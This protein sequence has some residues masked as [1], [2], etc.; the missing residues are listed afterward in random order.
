MIIILKVILRSSSSTILSAFLSPY[1][2]L[3]SDQPIGELKEN[4]ELANIF[5]KSPNFFSS[6]AHRLTSMKMNFNK[7]FLYQFKASLY[8]CKYRF[9]QINDEI[10][11]ELVSRIII[12]GNI[13]FIH[14]LSSLTYYSDILLN[15][16]THLENIFHLLTEI[17]RT[18]S[19]YCS[20][21]LKGVQVKYAKIVQSNSYDEEDDVE[22]A[23]SIF[24]ENYEEPG[25][26]LVGIGNRT[27]FQPKHFSCPML[28]SLYIL[29]SRIIY[30]FPHYSY[31]FLSYDYPFSSL[32]SNSSS[33]S[34]FSFTF[35]DQ[36]L[37]DISSCLTSKPKIILNYINSKSQNYLTNGEQFLAQSLNFTNTFYQQFMEELEDNES[38]SLYSST[39]DQ[40][41]HRLYNSLNQFFLCLNWSFISIQ[42]I[43]IIQLSHSITPSDRKEK[44]KLILQLANVFLTRG[45]L[46]LNFTSSYRAIERKNRLFLSPFD[47]TSQESNES[48]GETKYLLE[49]KI[50]LLSA[51]HL[52]RHLNSTFDS[53][54]K[55]C[56]LQ[57]EI[58]SLITPHFSPFDPFDFIFLISSFPFLLSDQIIAFSNTNESTEE[59][60]ILEEGIEQ[61]IK[62]EDDKL[63][64]NCLATNIKL[65]VCSRCKKVRYCSRECQL[66]DWPMHKQFCSISS[67]KKN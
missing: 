34:N 56:Q 41:Y 38:I 4:R 18:Y 32:T 21:K 33:S 24:E 16:S 28:I 6:I 29:I 58:L 49:G 61:I 43:Q 39:Q 13:H 35:D 51:L 8:S 50:S 30:S 19:E 65:R 15:N 59:Y 48:S 46:I 60:R 67:N 20:S 42:L 2:L 54:G 52:I 10:Y 5:I 27:K 64:I 31:S 55:Y 12:D 57:S 36:K 45:K 53:S 47:I 14:S 3:T 22:I 11:E 40:H 37:Q 7:E 66:D 23:S 44:E 9:D 62:E 1:P 26:Y 17:S 25:N 63:C